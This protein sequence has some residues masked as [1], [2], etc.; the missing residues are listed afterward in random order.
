[1]SMSRSGKIY[2]A[3]GGRGTSGL[4][5]TELK[6]AQHDMYAR[7]ILMGPIP[8]RN[9]EQESRQLSVV[10]THK[11]ITVNV[12][13]QDFP[14]IKC[15]IIVKFLP[16]CAQASWQTFLN[17]ISVK[18]DVQFIHTLIDRD[19]NSPVH[20]TLRLRD[21]GQYLVRQREE[22][23]VLETLYTG[24]TPTQ[25]SWPITG[26]INTALDDLRLVLLHP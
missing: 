19:D 11:I 6:K 4:I 22:S 25:I 12:A 10:E 21:K 15:D 1:M 5:A 14:A 20:R 24:V 18:L 17:D 9:R 7:T 2:N 26:E 3:G 16:S 8:M 13:R 23:A